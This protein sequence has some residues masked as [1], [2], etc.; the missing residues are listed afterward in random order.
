MRCEPYFRY[1]KNQ[2]IAKKPKRSLGIASL[3][4]THCRNCDA[5]NV[6]VDHLTKRLELLILLTIICFTIVSLAI[7]F[8]AV[9]LLLTVVKTSSTTT[10]ITT[11]KENFFC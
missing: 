2:R 3:T 6:S 9:Y 5:K 10:T 11:S 7:L 1:S 8:I 4:N